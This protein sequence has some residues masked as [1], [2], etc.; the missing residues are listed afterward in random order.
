MQTVFRQPETQFLGIKERKQLLCQ[1]AEYG[2]RFVM[3]EIDR[4]LY[5]MPMMADR[6]SCGHF[7]KLVRNEIVVLSVGENWY[8]T[9]TTGLP[10]E[11]KMFQKV[12]TVRRVRVAEFRMLLTAESY[13]SSFAG[14]N[15]LQKIHFMIAHPINPRLVMPQATGSVL[16]GAG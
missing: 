2:F 3:E 15:N 1:I 6:M 13:A 9:H 4:E 7:G 12:F 11:E 5:V 8:H 10:I 14:H 16:I